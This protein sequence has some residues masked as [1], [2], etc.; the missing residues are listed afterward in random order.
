LIDVCLKTLIC[1]FKAGVLTHPRRELCGCGI[2]LRTLWRRL[3]GDPH[4]GPR[5]G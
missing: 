2:Y 5:Q 4:R 3:V 1:I